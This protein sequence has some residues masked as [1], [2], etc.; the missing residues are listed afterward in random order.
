MTHTNHNQT[1]PPLVASRPR[2]PQAAMRWMGRLVGA[3]FGL[4]AG[5]VAGMILLAALDLDPE[6]TAAGFVSLG[7]IIAGVWLVARWFG[8]LFAGGRG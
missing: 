7:C 6:R 2:D 1:R 3:V 8:R 5:V 4:L